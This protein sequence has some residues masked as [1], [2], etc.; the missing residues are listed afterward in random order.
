MSFET[1]SERVPTKTEVVEVMAGFAEGG[2]EVREL[3]DEQGLYLLEIEK[4]GE[5]KGEVN[6]YTYM[7]KGDFS[8]SIATTETHINVVYMEDNYPVGGNTVARYIP[9]SGEWE[10]VK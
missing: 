10:K 9:E 3:S 2:V 4:P 6:L 1:N 8:N 5:K 7:R